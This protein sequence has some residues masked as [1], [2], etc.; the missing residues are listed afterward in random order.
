MSLTTGAR[1]NNQAEFSTMRQD[2]SLGLRLIAAGGRAVRGRMIMTTVGIALCVLVLLAVSAIFRAA[3][4]RTERASAASP[5]QTDAA[6]AFTVVDVK[7][8]VGQTPVYGTD[9]AALTP[10]SPAPPGVSH[11]PKP[12]ELIVSPA[13]AALLASPQGEQLR[14]R[15]SGD[16]VGTIDPAALISPAD[17][18][19]YRGV[20]SNPDNAP[21]GSQWAAAGLFSW[22]ND[23]GLSGSTELLLVTGSVVVLFPLLVF[24]ALCG[25]LGGAARDRRNAA[26][27]LVGASVGQLR[28]LAGVE[29][30]VAGIAG[31][32][33]GVAGFLLIRLAA[34]GI[35]YGGHVLTAGE[36]VPRGQMFVAVVVGAPL[37]AVVA[38]LYGSRGSRDTPL[39]VVR[40]TQ[41]R[42][43][44]WWRLG[45][46]CLTAV[47]CLPASAH[48]L[49]WLEQPVTIIAV[50][51]TVPVLLPLLLDLVSRTGSAGSPAWRIAIGRIRQ[52]TVGTARMVSGVSVVLAGAI[53]LMTLLTGRYE[54]TAEPSRAT[55]FSASVAD[56]DGAV[57]ALTGISGVTRI[58]AYASS[59]VT[60]ID[61]TTPD[62]VVATCPTLLD[63]SSPVSINT[64]SCQ[65]G[66]SFLITGTAG[67]HLKAG[68]RVQV[69][70]ENG[71]VSVAVPQRLTRIEVPAGPYSDFLVLT[72]AA[73]RA[74]T[75]TG[76]WRIDITAN[77]PPAAIDTARNAIAGLG[78]QVTVNFEPNRNVQNWND[79][80]PMLARTGLLIGAA[81]TLLVCVLGQFAMAVEHLADRRR[82]YALAHACGVPTGVL[83]RAALLTAAIPGLAGAVLGVLAGLVL[84]WA[85]VDVGPLSAGWA[86]AGGGAIALVVLVVALAALG[87]P[88]V[89]R[90]ARIEGLRTA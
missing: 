5:V 35:S 75:G 29:L 38:G 43:K 69:S 41:P 23:T 2:V 51:L 4:G 68:E 6:A 86:V 16:I 28:R 58:E 32:A 34:S 80:S 74:V 20:S 88:L 82:G 70:N 83:S 18:A 37:L 10:T 46:L 39:G 22:N 57:A 60:E 42:P 24:V 3:A 44:V 76:Q 27:R 9:L 45:Y 8:Y 67:G 73:A 31:A 1:P 30:A 66:D 79:G 25:R 62:V 48:L 11:F 72:P 90:A 50:L 52:D 36:L 89:R 54:P 14:P 13:L 78:A 59:P 63:G 17:L 53:A 12:G 15:L 85:L 61:D 26:I 64:D 21:T 84:S 7:M 81:L 77:I 55:I 33:L 19:F 65:D 56:L 47:L 71:A 49:D 87:I 40:R